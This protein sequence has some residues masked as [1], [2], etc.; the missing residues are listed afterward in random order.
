ML[1][2]WRKGRLHEITEGGGVEGL[3]T[4]K[5][6]VMEWTE[7]PGAQW[8]RE[9]TRDYNFKGDPMLYANFYFVEEAPTITKTVTTGQ[10]ILHQW[11][12]AGTDLEVFY[13]R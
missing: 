10:L 6:L 1:K 4:G 5:Q 8:A 2:K 11:D 3:P 7:L 9:H 12:I 13:K